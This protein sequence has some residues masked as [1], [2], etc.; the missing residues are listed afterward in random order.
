MAKLSEKVTD[1][2]PSGMTTVE[3]DHSNTVLENNK[4]YLVDVS[5][6]SASPELTLPGGAPNYKIHIKFSG[7]ALYQIKVIPA[8]GETI[9]LADGRSV[10][11]PDGVLF[12]ANNSE[13]TLDW[14]STNSHWVANFGTDSAN[15]NL[16]GN[17][18]VQGTLDANG[19]FTNTLSTGSELFTK[20]NGD[21]IILCNDNA[22]KSIGISAGQAGSYGG[23]G[24]VGIK[25][26]EGNGVAG[27]GS[28]DMYTDG[29]VTTKIITNH[30]GINMTPVTSTAGYPLQV[31][32][33]AAQCYISVGNASVG[34]G[35]TNGVIF[36]CDANNAYIF[37]NE[38]SPFAI[39]AGGSGGVQLNSGA[40]AWSTYSDERMKKNI[41]PLEYGLSEVL[42]I[43]P[44]RF[45]YIE[46]A[47]E[48]SSRVG[49][50]AQN[51]EPVVKEAISKD[52]TD[53]LG[54]SDTTLIPV[55][56]NSIKEQQAQIEQL[57]AE[58]EALKNN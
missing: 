31:Y 5:G 51:V 34:S 24:T 7:Q 11:A 42:K 44:V 22:A 4:S 17:W 46:D 27:A 6:A 49:F 32:S 33:P 36:G 48:S 9:A 29:S 35:P 55:L 26:T 54:I 45:D 2:I 57:K 58:I 43:N 39:Q 20:D 12:G 21:G 16:N 28:I 15:G 10:T 1:V 50:I 19:V 52:H 18:V 38:A 56:I 13:C 14:D 30:V 3:I 40:N 23:N 53:M 47:S 8:T 25:C 37:Q 41:Q